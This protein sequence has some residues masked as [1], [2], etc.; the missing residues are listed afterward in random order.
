MTAFDGKGVVVQVVAQRFVHAR[1]VVLKRLL[2]P[3]VAH[4]PAGAGQR[5]QRGHFGVEKLARTGSRLHLGAQALVGFEQLDGAL[6][7]AVQRIRVDD[8]GHDPVAVLHLDA[9]RQQHGER[10]DNAG[11]GAANAENI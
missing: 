3:R 6:L 9:R 5:G 10:A 8:N 1:E 2:H 4:L 7:V 11:A